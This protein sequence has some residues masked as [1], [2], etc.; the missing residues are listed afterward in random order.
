MFYVGIGF[1]DGV[2]GKVEIYVVRGHVILAEFLGPLWY[3]SGEEEELRPGLTL[4]FELIH[5]HFD[6][7]F[8][9]EWYHLVY[10]V[11]YHGLKIWKIDITSLQVIFDPTSC[12][13]YYIN[14][15]SS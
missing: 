14:L 4:L 10:F 15:I 3:G 13:N 1:V 2:F 12:S 7:V 11:N 8:E 6:V 5:D 9:V